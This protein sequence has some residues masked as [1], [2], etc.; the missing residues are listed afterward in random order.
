MSKAGGKKVKGGADPA[1]KWDEGL[2]NEQLHSVR[3][4]IID[5]IILSYFLCRTNGSLL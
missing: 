2:V 5:R 3:N 1:V 4:S